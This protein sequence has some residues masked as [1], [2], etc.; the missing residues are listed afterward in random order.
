MFFSVIGGLGIFL[1]GMKNMSDGIQAVAG[2]RLRKM[3]NAVTDNRLL[4]VGVGTGVTCLVQSSSITTVIVVGLVNGGLMQLHQAIGVIMGA[5]IGTTITGWILVLKIGKYG[6]PILGFSV[7]GYLFAKKDTLR[8]LAMGLMG[9]GMIFFGLEMMKNGFKPMRSVPMFQDAFAWF[10]ADSY[11]GVLKCAMAGCL[12]TFLVQSS[13]ATL[14]ITIGLASTGAIPFETAAAL[15]LGENIGTTITA[16]LASIGTTT[17]AKRAAYAHVMFNLIGVAWVTAIFLVYVKLV[18][19]FV[20]WESGANPISIRP[21]QPGFAQTVTFGI[22]AVHTGFNITNTLI[23]LPFVRPF[24]RFLERVIPDRSAKEVGRL[25][26]L[27][28]RLIESPILALETSRGEIVKMGYGVRKMMNW[29][30]ETLEAG[31]PDARLVRK[32]LHRESVMDNVQQEVIHFLTEILSAETPMSA[33]L[34]ARQQLRIADEYESVSDYVS[35]IVKARLKLEEHEL[36]LTQKQREQILMLHDRVAEYVDLVTNAFI[37]R[38][39]DIMTRAA[40][41]S[42]A[43]TA[44]VKELRSAHLESLSEHRVDPVASMCYST[45]LNGYRKVKDHALN[46]AES[47]AA[48]A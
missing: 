2:S 5:N 24:A 21:D 39:P 42:D 8:Y 38:K 35:T 46:I 1:I 26:S 14:G 6:L 44:L 3:I 16:W 27:D 41:D 18:G 17:I 34:E 30:R 29:T 45:M 28:M 19:H 9:L 20:E 11:F 10:V 23:F 15:V 12:L 25:D 37:E 40:S 43:I 13:S 4:A 32:I 31:E 33:A 47:M 36:E 48:P 22:A 7:F